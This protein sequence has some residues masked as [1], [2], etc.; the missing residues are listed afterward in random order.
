MGRYL[1]EAHLREG[2]SVAELASTHGVDRSWIYKLLARSRAEGDAGL[3]PRS[4]RPH[5]SP[6]R[7]GAEVEEEIVLVRKQLVEEGLD[8]GAVTIHWHL[9][10]RHDVVP[11]VSTIWRVL[12]R[13]G[14][15][16]AVRELCDLVLETRAP[17]T[18]APG[19][20]APAAPPAGAGDA[21]ASSESR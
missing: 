21:P 5:R 4:R 18:A 2:R 20:T 9:A 16:G 14:G 15:H 7:L 1:V 12:S 3:V 6:T 13:R 19:S 8:A 17:A 10:R 11:S